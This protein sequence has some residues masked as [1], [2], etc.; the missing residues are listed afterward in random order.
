M[1]SF[2]NQKRTLS[3][4]D[5]KTLEHAVKELLQSSSKEALLENLTIYEQKNK[6]AAR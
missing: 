6:T 5:K 4:N 2:G 3:P 1:N